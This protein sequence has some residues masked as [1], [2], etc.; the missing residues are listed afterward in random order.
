MTKDPT[1]GDRSEVDPYDDLPDDIDRAAVRRMRAV[2][3]LL[4]D[5]VRVPG[6][7][8]RVGLDPILGI[9]PGAGDAVSAAFSFYIVVESARLGVSPPTLVRMLANVSVDVA[10]GSVPIVGDLFDAAWKANRRNVEL[11]VAELTST[12]EP[13]DTEPTQIEIE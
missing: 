11:A 1:G 2:A 12:P 8:F 13:A 3:R 7:D 6:T 5:S 9:L 10:G 4:D